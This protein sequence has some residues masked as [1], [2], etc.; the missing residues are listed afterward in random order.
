MILLNNYFRHTIIV[1][2]SWDPDQARLIFGPY[3]GPNCLQR[4]STDDTSKQGVK[5]RSGFR[6]DISIT[7]QEAEN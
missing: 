3:L 6:I 4:L 1:L 2:N 5:S 7:S